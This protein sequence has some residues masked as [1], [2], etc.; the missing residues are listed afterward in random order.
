MGLE[1]ERCMPQRQ[2]KRLRQLK[3]SV[4]TCS[5]MTATRKSRK[6]IVDRILNNTSMSAMITVEMHGEETSAATDLVEAVARKIDL[7]AVLVVLMTDT[8]RTVMEAEDNWIAH[9]NVIV[10]EE[11][12]EEQLEVAEVL[13]PLTAMVVQA[14]GMYKMIVM[15]R[16]RDRL[17]EAMR[18]IEEDTEALL[19]LVVVAILAMIGP[20]L[21]IAIELPLNKTDMGAIVLRIV[22]DKVGVMEVQE[23]NT[24]H[25]NKTV[26]AQVAAVVPA[27]ADTIKL[28]HSRIVMDK[29][30]AAAVVVAVV[31]EMIGEVPGRHLLSSRNSIL[32]TP[33]AAPP[34]HP[35]AWPTTR[36]PSPSLAANSSR[37]TTAHRTQ[38]AQ[39]SDASRE[40][41]PSPPTTSTDAHANKATAA[42]AAVAVDAT[43]TSSL[44]SLKLRNLTCFP[45]PVPSSK[46]ARSSHLVSL[47]GWTETTIPSELTH[48]NSWKNPPIA[49]VENRNLR[50]LW[51][52]SRE[53]PNSTQEVTQFNSRHARP[54]YTNVHNAPIHILSPLVFLYS[55]SRMATQKLR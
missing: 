14:I 23:A 27:M 9:L 31:M 35:R 45:S 1:E 20:L 28:L 8:E 51:M 26:T 38:I 47:L 22:M 37:K 24:E 25:S 46:E 4:T 6:D 5:M 19:L 18:T 21:T 43:A 17:P 48:I 34:P 33:L 11:E 54:N 42:A 52:K 7:A 16:P 2:C 50:L 32:A 29:V 15:V 3:R 44:E 13:L 36:M 30:P 12:E 53:Q 55:L 39:D 10:M 40:P 41:R 49:T